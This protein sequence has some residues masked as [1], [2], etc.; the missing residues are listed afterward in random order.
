M[1]DLYEEYPKNFKNCIDISIPPPWESIVEECIDKIILINP[2]VNILQI[3]EKYAQLRIYIDGTDEDTVYEILNTA[4][5]RCEKTCQ[6]CGEEGEFR[7]KGRWYII[8]C[9]QCNQNTK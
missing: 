8:L 5:A 7:T 1:K 9:E 6:F 4:K 2:D 3:K